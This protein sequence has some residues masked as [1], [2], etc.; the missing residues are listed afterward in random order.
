MCICVVQSPQDFGVR[1][2]QHFPHVVVAHPLHVLGQSP[3]R[4]QNRLNSLL[5]IIQSDNL[6]PLLRQLDFLDLCLCHPV[7]LKALR[8]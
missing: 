1:L 7:P 3:V 5:K 4:S 8:L 6:L 2:L